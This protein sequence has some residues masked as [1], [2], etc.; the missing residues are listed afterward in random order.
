M[1]VKELKKFPAKPAYEDFI[2]AHV[3]CDICG[4]RGQDN[5]DDAHWGYYDH[6]TFHETEVRWRFGYAYPEG[7]GGQEYIIHICPK[8]FDKKLIPWLTEQGATLS[9]EEWST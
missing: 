6:S 3:K 1:K 9:T 5:W 4:A 8:C 7:G 2:V